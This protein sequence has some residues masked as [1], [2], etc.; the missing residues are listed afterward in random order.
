[1]WRAQGRRYWPWLSVFL[2]AGCGFVGDPLPPAL[3]IPV[4]ITDLRGLEYGPNVLVEF[5][6]PK[7]TT[8]GLLLKEY[9]LE[10]FVGPAVNPF[11]Y[12]RWAAGATKFEVPPGL[13]TISA[14]EPVKAWVGKEITVAVRALGPKG[15]PSGWS[16]LVSF[17]AAEPLATPTALKTESVLRGVAVTWSG[18]GPRYRI[19]RAE[20]EGMPERFNETNDPVYLD[21]TTQY[22]VRYRYLVQAFA[23]E[24]HQS[25]MAEAMP[26]TPVDTFA[27]A[28]PG[29]V[30]AVAGV[31]TI[32]LA[33]TR[34]GEPD[35]KGYNVYRSLDNGPYE[36][37]G[38][39]VEAPAFT[40]MRV[41]AGRRYRY[42]VTAVDVLGN[43]SERSNP[44]EVVA[45]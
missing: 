11:S 17:I 41:Q 39:L 15:R 22:G 18:S 34:N 20:G 24:S 37:V 4:A 6:A 32:E 44:V 9:K 1:M 26:I 25:A 23:D 43:E 40:D 42:V 31:N 27:P 28:V 21:E 33:W 36:K 2:L 16:N 29:A 12:E 7:L 19:Y 30:T 35:F 10:V 5:S 38:M 8:E 45:Q 13:G 3:N 14:E